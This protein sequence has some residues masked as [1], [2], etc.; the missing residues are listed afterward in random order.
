TI[1]LGLSGLAVVNVS[2]WVTLGKLSAPVIRSTSVLPNAR[3]DNSFW[4]S[5]ENALP[6]EALPPSDRPQKIIMEPARKFSCLSMPSSL[7]REQSIAAG[8]SGSMALEAMPY[9]CCIS[10][11][12]AADRL[13]FCPNG[14][15]ARSASEMPVIP[16]NSPIKTRGLKN[17]DREVDFFFMCGYGVDEVECETPLL[18]KAPAK[19]QYFSQKTFRKLSLFARQNSTGSSR[20]LRS[21]RFLGQFCDK[22]GPGN[23]REA[24]KTSTFL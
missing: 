10:A 9:F 2:D 1:W 6:C 17:A 3:G 15:A 23:D 20:K 11:S 13:F 8:T 21:G 24:S 22:S 5:L 4:A 16:T 7:M 12:C 18:P 19:C 14:L